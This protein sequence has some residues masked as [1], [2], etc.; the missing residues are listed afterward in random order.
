MKE[1]INKLIE[2][3]KEWSD[4]SLKCFGWGCKEYFLEGKL[5]IWCYFS[6]DHNHQ[7]VNIGPIRIALYKDAKIEFQQS[8]F[9]KLESIY[10][11][12]KQC[13]LNEQKIFADIASE[14][15]ERSKQE[16]ITAL[17]IELE[18]LEEESKL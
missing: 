17:K 15:L 8:S 9:D 5:K 2:L 3:A 7:S 10:K 1:E 4:F 12:A 16:R 14:E 11:Y 6:D 18:R 13:L